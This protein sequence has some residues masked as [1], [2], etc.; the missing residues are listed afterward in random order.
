M[1]PPRH[2]HRGF[3]VKRVRGQVRRCVV[4]DLPDDDVDPAVPERFPWTHTLEG[5]DELDFYRDFV[6]RWGSDKWI[7]L[8]WEVDDAFSDANLHLVRELTRELQDVPG[9]ASVSSLD[10]AASVETG[11]F[12]P[13][14]RPLVPD[15]IGSEPGLRE[16]AL[17]NGF[18][19]DQLVSRDGKLLLVAVQLEAT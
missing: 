4:G 5:S 9:V 19:R 17:A 16:A 14:V 1:L 6:A 15:E 7:V 10:T 18:V 13:F 2:H 11:P 8:A 12:G 3:L